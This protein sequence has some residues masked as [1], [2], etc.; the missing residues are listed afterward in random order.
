VPE[1]AKN[2]SGRHVVIGW[3]GGGEAA[4]AVR[5]SRG[6]LPLFDK[7]EIVVVDEDPEVKKSTAAPISYLACHGITAE[8]KCI[9]GKSKVAGNLL[10]DYAAEQGADLIVMGAY[11][12]NRLREFIFGGAT[13]QILQDM[14]MPVYMAH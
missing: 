11:G 3:N 7:V 2:F 6:F 12:H 9:S 5:Q 14:K 1:G 8:A 4:S 10:M 13:R